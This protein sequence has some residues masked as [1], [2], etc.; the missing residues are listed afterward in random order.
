MTNPSKGVAKRV[1]REDRTA[2]WWID[3]RVP[4]FLR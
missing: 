3:T 2:D 4:A 1:V